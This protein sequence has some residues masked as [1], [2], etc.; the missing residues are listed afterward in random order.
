MNICCQFFSALHWLQE[1]VS[2]SSIQNPRFENCCK[3]GAIVLE[4]PQNVPEF[5][6]NLF[7]AD[8]PLSK[9]FRD[10]IRQYNS[11]LAFTSLK[12]TPDPRLP[13]GGI[14]NFRE[15]YHMQSLK[16]FF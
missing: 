8:N 9:H 5:I 14:Q 11:A 6:S 15:L 1:R 16:K 2:T 12:C 10:N 7:Q 13:V 4:A 3:Q